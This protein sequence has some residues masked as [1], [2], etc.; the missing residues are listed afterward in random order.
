MSQASIGLQ[1]R[2]AAGRSQCEKG[3]ASTRRVAT[4]KEAS[5]TGTFHRVVLCGDALS[6]AKSCASEDFGTAAALLDAPQ[7]IGVVRHAV[8]F[9]H[10]SDLYREI[11]PILALNI[12]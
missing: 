5:A 2:S 6:R 4:E 12:V 1:P 9:R 10:D 7:Q 3:S 11:V 8:H